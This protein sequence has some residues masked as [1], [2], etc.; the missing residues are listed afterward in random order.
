MLDAMYVWETEPLK[1]LSSTRA[2]G[3]VETK[4]SVK[5][6]FGNKN[7]PSAVF[8]VQTRTFTTLTAATHIPIHLKRLFDAE[9]STMSS[10]PEVRLK[11]SSIQSLVA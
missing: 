6:L 3:Q 9:A 5:G 1:H 10:L 8:K 7:A 11:S 2:P 4:R